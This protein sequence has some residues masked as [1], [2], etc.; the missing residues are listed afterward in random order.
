MSADTKANQHQKT[1]SGSSKKSAEFKR[2][3]W[4]YFRFFVPVVFLIGI[5]PITVFWALTFG[6]T[7]PTLIKDLLKNVTSELLMIVLILKLIDAKIDGV[8]EE[9]MAKI[10]QRLDNYLEQDLPPILQSQIVQAID[11]SARLASLRD[12]QQESRSRLGAILQKLNQL[13]RYQQKQERA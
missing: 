12:D 2:S 11:S 4:V 10:E 5:A 7:V 6:D 1:L 3:F 9:V 8:D 13:E